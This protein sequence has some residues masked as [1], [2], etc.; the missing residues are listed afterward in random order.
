MFKNGGWFPIFLVVILLTSVGGN[1]Y[2]VMRATNDPAFA[3][4]PDYYRKAVEWDKVQAE[5]EKSD[6]LGWH[7]LVDARQDELRIRLTDRLGRPVDGATVEVEAFANARASQ[8][9][10]GRLVPKGLGV[11]VLQRPFDRSG[12]WEYRLAAVRDQE[13]FTHVAQKELP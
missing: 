10:V 3:V 4:E 1:I 11:Y 7:V 9:I 8:R 5:Q 2:M 6:A 12:L 13:R